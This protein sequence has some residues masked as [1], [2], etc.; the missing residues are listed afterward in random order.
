MR[1]KRDLIKVLI[2]IAM[3][4]SYFF[5][6]LIEFFFEDINNINNHINNDYHRQS[7]TK[8]AFTFKYS[9]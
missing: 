6:K 7:I 9:F 4:S 5:A 3:I 2:E 8:Y 1:F